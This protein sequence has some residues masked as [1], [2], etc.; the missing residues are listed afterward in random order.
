MRTVRMI[1]LKWRIDGEIDHHL[2]D[3]LSCRPLALINRPAGEKLRATWQ[4]VTV[5][6]G[7]YFHSQS[8]TTTLHLEQVSLF[9]AMTKRGRP[10]AQYSVEPIPFI[11]SL[12]KS[13]MTLILQKDTYSTTLACSQNSLKLYQIKQI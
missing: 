6:H 11:L 9:L 13:Q 7:Y 5:S 3:L 4:F 1:R 2:S 8:L 12:T 10:A